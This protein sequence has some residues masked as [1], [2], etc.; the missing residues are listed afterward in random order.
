MAPLGIVLAL[1]EELLFRGFLMEQPLEP[2]L[3]EQHFLVR[4]TPQGADLLLLVPGGKGRGSH[5]QHDELLEM[6]AG[7]IIAA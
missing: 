7:R 4:R 5:P 3:I 6:R 1:G 2:L